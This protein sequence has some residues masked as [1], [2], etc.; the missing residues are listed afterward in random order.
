MCRNPLAMGLQKLLGCLARV[1]PRSIMDQKQ[2]LRGVGQDHLY[3]RL[4]TVRGKPVLEA[5]I[6]QAPRKILNSAKHFVAFALATGFDWGLLPAPRP[7]VAQRAPLGKTRL[8]FK[9]DQAFASLGRA[10]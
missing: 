6:E 8:I 4:I 10:E 9:Q 2:V 5:L 1:I 3:K 7:R